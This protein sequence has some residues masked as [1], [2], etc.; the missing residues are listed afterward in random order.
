MLHFQRAH[1]PGPGRLRPLGA[2]GVSL[3]TVLAL[4]ALLGTVFLPHEIRRQANRNPV[5]VLRFHRLNDGPADDCSSDDVRTGRAI[6]LTRAR[7][8]GP[9]GR[10]VWKVALAGESSWAAERELFPASADPLMTAISRN[11]SRLFVGNMAG[12]VFSLRMEATNPTP[13]PLPRYFDGALGDLCCSAD[14]AIL[15]ARGESGACAW[16][17]QTR[18]L[19]WSRTDLRLDRWA[20]DDASRQLLVTT[21]DRE[22]LE[23]DLRTGQT[24]RKIETLDCPNVALAL[25]SDGAQIARIGADGRLELIERAR[26][27]AAWPAGPMRRASYAPGVLAFSPCGRVLVAGDGADWQ[28]LAVWNV[29]TGERLGELRGH[30]EPIVAL[31]FFADG[32]MLT[33]GLDGAVRIW[34]SPAD[35]PQGSSRLVQASAGTRRPAE[36]NPLNRFSAIAPLSLAKGR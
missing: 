36:T 2:M 16:N 6:L 5:C 35:D 27:R 19:C 32:R 29:A 3:G 30:A 8:D 9:S 12:Q 10:F 11:G 13:A 4:T 24:L 22:L 18:R 17:T 7:E 28:T 20:I 14:G 31:A 26:G 1:S 25:S 23:L 15:L 33:S 34:N 21:E